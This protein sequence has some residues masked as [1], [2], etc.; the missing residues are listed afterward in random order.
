MSH[1]RVVVIS[2]SYLHCIVVVLFLYIVDIV[3]VVVVVVVVVIVVSEYAIAVCRISSLFLWS[4]SSSTSS[5]AIS[6]SLATLSL[7]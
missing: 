6:T 1:G 7:Q 4:R 2:A 3:V 5:R